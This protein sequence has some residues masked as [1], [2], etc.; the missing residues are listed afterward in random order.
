[1]DFFTKTG[2]KLTVIYCKKERERENMQDNNMMA[3]K[4]AAKIIQQDA[5]QLIANLSSRVNGCKCDPNNNCKSCVEDTALIKN[6]Y[7]HVMKMPW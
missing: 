1:M 2:R 5:K 3:I 6:A 4:I 7:T